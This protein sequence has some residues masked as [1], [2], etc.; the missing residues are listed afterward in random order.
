MN[1]KIKTFEINSLEELEEKLEEY[2]KSKVK[3]LLKEGIFIMEE[4][5]YFDQEQYNKFEYVVEFAEGFFYA[6]SREVIE[7]IEKK[8]LEKKVK[9]IGI[10]IDDE[11]NC[12]LL[13][14][15]F[16]KEEY[17]EEIFFTYKNKIIIALFI[18]FSFLCINFIFYFF[19]IKIKDEI[20]EKEKELR[21]IHQEL[22]VLEKKNLEEKVEENIEKN[23]EKKG[24]YKVLVEIESAVEEGV[25]LE[26]LEWNNENIRLRGKANSLN[27]IYKLEKK[28]YKNF[29]ELNNDYVKNQNN[30]YKFS[31]DFK[32]KEIDL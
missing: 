3:I 8:C 32:T 24:V 14:T 19:G 10:Y 6:L 26:V 28:L 5:V 22:K 1:P 23:I 4:L 13:E 15:N 21:E 31:L 12:K 25:K 7:D 17:K 27:A 11:K 18:F 2:K 9:L 16:F 20:A 29:K 30:I